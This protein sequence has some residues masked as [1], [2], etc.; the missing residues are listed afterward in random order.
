[1]TEVYGDQAPAAPGDALGRLSASA[2]GWH[3]IQ[4]AVLGFI[5]I[6]GVLRTADPAVPAGVQW[7]AGLLA[8]A[9]L[10]FACAAV[11][12]VGAVAFPID[13]R[14]AAADP[15]A[16]GQATARLRTGVRMTVVA[17]ILAVI[18]ALSG[19]WP[20]TSGG[21]AG[22]ASVTVSD[23]N[24]RSWCGSLVA[25]P[26]GAVSITTSSGSVAVPLQDVA[27]VRPVTGC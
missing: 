15:V 1:M 5:G 18:A 23:G 25:G 16:I 9:A 10:G 4:L 7:L 6:C 22:T 11:F 26:A 27:V 14:R 13:A 8:V 12:L 21:T 2:R 24:G 20:Q 19:W 3:A 17:L